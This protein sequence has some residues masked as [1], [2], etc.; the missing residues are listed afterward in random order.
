M[1]RTALKVVVPAAALAVIGLMTVVVVH[2]SVSSRESAAPRTNAA[3]SVNAGAENTFLAVTAAHLCNVGRAVYDDPKAL[4]KAYDSSPA[5]P[6]LSGD[7]VTALT[8]RLRTDQALTLRLAE[9]IR[10][11]CH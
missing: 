3:A 11:T 2:A 10:A 6:G 7:E 8:A 9:Q 5:Y 4:A 1:K